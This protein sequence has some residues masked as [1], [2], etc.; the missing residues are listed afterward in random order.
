A[1]K[2]KKSK[3]R[4]QLLNDV[5]DDILN[6]PVDNDSEGFTEI[7]DIFE[8]AEPTAEDLEKMSEETDIFDAGEGEI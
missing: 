3:P 6:I 8:S 1:K 2:Q 5:T 4:T 7:E